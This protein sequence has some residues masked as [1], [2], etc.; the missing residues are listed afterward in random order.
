MAE[1][2]LQYLLMFRQCSCQDNKILSS[3]CSAH[4]SVS[5][6]ARHSRDGGRW[7]SRAGLVF[8][9]TAEIRQ[10]SAVKC[11]A[12]ADTALTWC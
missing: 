8:R 6:R 12:V 5:R 9:Y 4:R 1:S 10:P 2:G 11:L 7:W 3:C